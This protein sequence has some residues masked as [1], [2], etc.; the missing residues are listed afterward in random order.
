MNFLLLGPSHLTRFYVLSICLFFLRL[1]HLVLGLSLS[2]AE[3]VLSL[4]LVR[5]LD[6]KITWVLGVWSVG[7]DTTDL[8]S[9]LDGQD[10]TEVED[11]LLPVCVLGVWAGGEADWLVAGGEIDIEPSD[12]GVDEVVTAGVEEE[13]GGEGK[14]GEGAL[15]EVEGEDGGWVGDNGLDLDSVDEWLSESSL[16]EWGVVETVDVV[17]EVDLLILVI[18]VL[19]SGNEDG[20]L[21]WEDQAAWNKVL[22]TGPEDGVQH[23]LVEEEVTHPLG[24]DDVDFWEWEDNILHLALKKGDL[25]GKT[26]DLHD[27]LGLDDDGGHVNTDNVLCASLCGKPMQLS[28]LVPCS[29]RLLWVC[30]TWREYRFHSRHRERSCP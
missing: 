10:I 17:P 25:V 28:V 9:L 24:D 5:D 29:Y 16:L 1:A 22:V 8:L 13:W 7:E 23:G 2:L 6:I 3:W 20:G 19:D 18:S 15:V 30:L 11:S 21:V 14:V 12:D 26:V 4:K 27:L